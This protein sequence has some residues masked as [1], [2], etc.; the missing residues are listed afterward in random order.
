MNNKET[1]PNAVVKKNALSALGCF[2]LEHEMMVLALAAIAVAFLGLYGMHDYLA[3]N[4]RHYNAIDMAYYTIQLFLFRTGLNM[5]S[6]SVHW[7]LGVA[8]ILA[9]AVLGYAAL[10]GLAVF[11]RDQLATFRMN[12]QKNHVVI[13]GLGGKGLQLVRDFRSRGRRVVVVEQ[14]AD[15]K[16]LA[17]VRNLGALVVIG[18]STEPSILRK[19]KA[20]RAESLLAFTGDD[21]VNVETGL[22]IYRMLK[23]DPHKN[24]R[25]LRCFIHLYSTNLASVVGRQA[26]FAMPHGAVTFEIVRTNDISARLLFTEHP[27]DYMEIPADSSKMPHCVIAG[28]GNMGESVAVQA[29]RTG[30]YARH[31]RIKIT[32]V[33]Q[34]A[35][36]VESLFFATYP[37]FRSAA[38]IG[39]IQ[40]DIESAEFFQMVERWA[41]DDAAITTLVIAV[42]NDT[43]TFACALNC[44]KRTKG[45]EIPI[46]VRLDTS[47]GIAALLQHRGG[48]EDRELSGIHPFGMLSASCNMTMIENQPIDFLAQKIHEEY[49]GKRLK[50]EE[51]RP[52]AERRTPDNDPSLYPWGKLDGSLKDSNR[53]QADHIPVKLR[54]I[55]CTTD[56]ARAPAGA[57]PV[58]AFTVEEIELLSIMEHDRWMADRFIAGWQPGR[59]RNVQSRISPFLVPWEE[60]EK[61]IKNRDLEAMKNIPALLEQTG[62]RIYRVKAAVV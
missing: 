40:S 2:F 31:G 43:K 8:R 19:A 21:G 52:Q 15:I 30:H 53:Q 7:T 23:N 54:A 32:V 13:C 50:E 18:N 55:G 59:E 47:E 46:H 14:C 36:N 26:F 57:E 28:F 24:T 12:F 6:E 45:R 39:F 20:H 48:R 17:T 9:P 35:K 33:D 44:A 42:H 4:G 1:F 61:S 49:V 41:L 34:N 58:K 10:K 38:D 5:D 56:P 22:A 62:K 60:L 27:L 25:P 51:G 3:R 37:N 11:F 16:E 29:A